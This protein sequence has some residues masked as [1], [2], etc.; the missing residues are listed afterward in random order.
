LYR[1]GADGEETIVEVY[2]EGDHFGEFGLFADGLRMTHAQAM[3]P[4]VC[5]E[6]GERTVLELLERSPRAMRLML[7]SLSVSSRR[8]LEG[9][10]DLAFG[11]I[12]ARVAGKLLDLAEVH[13][14][15][16]PDGIRIALKMSQGELAS[17]IAASRSNVNRALAEL[18]A[19]GVVE[20]HH[21]H[22]TILQPD[23]LRRAR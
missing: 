6:L 1:L 20:H 11:D 19:D 14:E 12:A 5:I 9:F 18:M 2:I 3:M 23:R 22:F 7:H 15:P 8:L 16:T 4:T 21:G 13:G 10:T 17:M